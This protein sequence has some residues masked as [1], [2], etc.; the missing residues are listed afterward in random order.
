VKDTA[1]DRNL[2][3]F[4][5]LGSILFHLFLVVWIASVF[6]R[7][8]R[9]TVTAGGASAV[10]EPCLDEAQLQMMVEPDLPVK[11][12]ILPLTPPV[13]LALARPV[14]STRNTSSI[15]VAAVVSPPAFR[16]PLLWRQ[17]KGSHHVR[18]ATPTPMSQQAKGALAA[19]PDELHNDPPVY[20][21][22]S[23]LAH[24]EGLVILQVEVTAEGE[25]ASVSIQKS[26]GFFRLDRAAREAVKHWRFHPGS[27]AG[28][29]VSSTAMVPVHF[30][31]E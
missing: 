3:L 29:P 4:C 8:A 20:P 10:S 16:S 28:A 24:E 2:R 23:R 1:G 22:E 5:W 18:H 7:M 14:N 31:L 21:D 11:P 30:R 19:E 9:F 27:R 15:P 6:T 26:S 17:S 25:A 12:V 13:P